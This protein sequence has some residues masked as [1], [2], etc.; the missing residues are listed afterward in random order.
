MREMKT[1]SPFFSI[2]IP[3]YNAS[4]TLSRCLDSVLCQN[5]QDFEVI[6]IDD[7]STDL[8]WS[9]LGQYVLKDARIKCFSQLNAGPSVARNKGLDEA[10]G[11]YV[12]FVD[13]DDYYYVDHALS[14][15]NETIIENGD[16]D[17]VYFALSR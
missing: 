4:S 5:F 8:S 1:S 7:G 16:C 6:C 3:V 14:V 9:I 17:L 13:A 10:S 2:I 11:K 12:L 15:L